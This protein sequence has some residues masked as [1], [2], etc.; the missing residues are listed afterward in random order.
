MTYVKNK[1]VYKLNKNKTV[2]KHS[3]YEDKSD[4]RRK[5][6]I[7]RETLICNFVIITIFGKVWYM[8]YYCKPTMDL[9][10]K[11]LKKKR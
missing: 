10:E 2:R 11:T 1:T 6:V 3:V 7:V 9:Y 4:T 5:V 8:L